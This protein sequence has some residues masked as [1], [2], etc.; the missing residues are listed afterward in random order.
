[1]TLSQPASVVTGWRFAWRSKRSF[2][3]SERG[4]LRIPALEVLSREV[5]TFEAPGE[6]FERSRS[7][8]VASGERDRIAFAQEKASRVAEVRAVGATALLMA[9]QERTR[10]R[11]AIRERERDLL[12]AGLSLAAALLVA[13]VRLTG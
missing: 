13:V 6:P 4:I 1:V 5:S 9:R 7:S 10:A 12:L 8:G 2:A 11:Q 3:F